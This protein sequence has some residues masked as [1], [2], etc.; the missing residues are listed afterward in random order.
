VN[1]D[2]PRKSPGSE[3]GRSALSEF[4]RVPASS[5]LPISNKVGFLIGV[6]ADRFFGDMT[7]IL[8]RKCSTTFKQFQNRQKFSRSYSRG[9]RGGVVLSLP[10][11]LQ[12]GGCGRAHGERQGGGTTTIENGG[13]LTAKTFTATGGTVTVNGILDPT[14]VE[15]DSG[16]TLQGTG[17][18][19][20][21]VAMGGTIMP[22]APGTPGTL[23]VFGNYE[24]IGNGTF[25]ELIGA[26]SASF[27]N[28]NGDAALD[29]DSLLNITLLNGYDPLGQTFGIMG[30]RSLVGQFSNGS[31]F[32]DDGFVWDISYGKNEIYVTAVG[33]P[34]PS[35][36]LLLF[37][38]L[39]ALAFC[40]HSKVE[41]ARRLA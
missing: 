39:F 31:S 40:A 29:F 10:L 15:I 22:G 30:Y 11:D 18:I 37:L 14:A 33:T 8:T 2:V 28:V 32:L 9:R 5:S 27:L 1:A 7:A 17:A 4:A 6:T 34:E 26:N 13:L 35:S 36:L 3:C 25:D 24:Q 23:T 41:K 20:G 19:I 21:N 12:A 16:A 38:G